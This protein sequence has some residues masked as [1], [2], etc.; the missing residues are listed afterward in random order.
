MQKITLQFSNHDSL[1]SFKDHSTSV[2]VSVSPAKRTVT[3]PFSSE[4]VN[5]ALNQFNATEIMNSP[6]ETSIPLKGNVALQAEKSSLR[7][8]LHSF[9]SLMNL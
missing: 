4:E 3:G 9:L 8:R 5:L 2:N 6:A 7:Q 1:W